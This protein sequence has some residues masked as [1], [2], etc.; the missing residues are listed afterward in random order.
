MCVML[1]VAMVDEAFGQTVT[2]LAQGTL[3]AKL[4]CPTASS[5]GVQST[6]AGVRCLSATGAAV[7]PILDQSAGVQ[8]EVNATCATLNNVTTTGITVRLVAGNTTGTCHYSNNSTAGASVVSLLRGVSALKL[9]EVK[10]EL[11]SSKQEIK[12]E[13]ID[14]QSIVAVLGYAFAFMA[15]IMIGVNVLKTNFV[16]SD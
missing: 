9:D 5:F 13:L 15:G 3:S 2:R 7:Q 1:V 14:V 10:A 16:A 11:I 8:V 6:S 12:T 4:Y